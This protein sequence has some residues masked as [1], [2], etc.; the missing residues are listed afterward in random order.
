MVL[1]SVARLGSKKLISEDLKHEQM[2]GEI[3][4]INP[5]IGVK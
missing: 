3:Q 2:Y 1:H 4:V 5:F